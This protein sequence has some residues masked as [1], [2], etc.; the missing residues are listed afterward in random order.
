LV[1]NASCFGLNEPR[2]ANVYDQKWLLTLSGVG[3][4][5]FG[6]A[7][8]DD[9]R[10]ATARLV[11]DIWSPI[12]WATSNYGIPLPPPSTPFEYAFQVEQWAPCATMNSIFDQNQSIDAGFSVN[13]WSLQFSEGEVDVI[14]GAMVGMLWNGFNVDLAIRDTDAWLY[15]AGFT[16]TLLGKIKFIEP[17]Q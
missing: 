6:G 4:C 3:I 12:T 17:E 15:R 5:N 9:W 16:V 14:T 11:T 2:P 1:N 7:I 10:C 13:S 8:N